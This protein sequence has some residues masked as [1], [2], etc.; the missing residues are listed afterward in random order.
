MQIGVNLLLSNGYGGQRLLPFSENFARPDG[1]LGNGWAGATWAIASGKAVNTPT[2]GAELLTNGNMETGDPPT[3]WTAENATLSAAADERTGG[4]GIASLQA[5]ATTANG[6][7]WKN[8][9]AAVGDW[10]YFNGYVKMVSG[11]GTVFLR[12]RTYPGGINMSLSSPSTNGQ[13]ENRSVTARCTSG[14]SVIASGYVF[15][16]SAVGRFDDFTVKKIT[17]LIA[18]RNVGQTDQN[19]TGTYSALTTG[20]Q[21]GVKANVSADGTSYLVAWI[22]GVN[23][24]LEKNVAGTW[25]TLITAAQAPAASKLPQIKT[26]VSGANLLVDLLYNGVTIGTQQTVSNAEIVSNTYAGLFSTYLGN[27]IATFSAAAN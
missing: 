10:I 5:A 18:R 11:G 13:W 17:N 8:P 7:T 22:D 15:T 14:T 3:G 1:P 20:T 16:T 12:L 4:V 19:I 26:T 27:Q 25:T 6:Y 24:G 9:T 21:L 23:I 2:Q